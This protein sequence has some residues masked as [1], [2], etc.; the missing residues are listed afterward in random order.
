MWNPKIIEQGELH[1]LRL[2]AERA[3]GADTKQSAYRN[4]C[5]NTSRWLQTRLGGQVGMKDGHFVWLSPDSKYA[6]DLTGDTSGGIMLYKPTDHPFFAGVEPV[7]T[8]LFDDETTHRMIARADDEY[9]NIDSKLSKIALDYA[10]DSHPAQEPQAQ[11]DYDQ[12][13]FHHSP[14]TDEI[15]GEYK[16]VYANGN[17]EISPYSDHE[18]LAQEAGISLDQSGPLAVGYISV[19]RGIAN[20][21]V[22]SNIGAKIIHKIVKDYTDHVGWKWGGLT[23]IT[24]EPIGQGS[25]FAPKKT[26]RW[27]YANGTLYL[28]ERDADLIKQICGSDTNINVSLLSNNVFGACFL[29]QDNIFISSLSKSNDVFFSTKESKSTLSGLVTAFQ[30]VADDKGLTLVSGLPGDGWAD[31]KGGVGDN[32]IK[33]IEDLELDNL[34]D[35]NPKEENDGQFFPS[36]DTR[37]PSGTYKCDHCGR[38]LPTWRSY[39]SHL[40]DHE[41]P[42]DEPNQDGKF[43]ELDNDATFP[44]HFTPLQ[45]E[46]FP[47]ASVKEARRVP[48]FVK[49]ARAKGYDNDDFC[50]YVAFADGDPLAYMSVD[51][52]GNIVGIGGPDSHILKKLFLLNA[53]KR[54]SCLVSG[55]TKGTFSPYGFHMISKNKWKWAAGQDHK[56]MIEDSIPFI[57]D[58][59]DDKITIG[60]PGMKTSQIPGQFTP[61]GIVEGTYEPGGK[62]YIRSATNMPYTIR[63]LV[64][65]F[66]YE[67]PTLEVKSVHL[68][69]EE[70]KDK[71]LA[72]DRANVVEISDDGAS[73]STIPGFGPRQP[74]VYTPDSDTVYL[75]QQRTYHDDIH[76]HLNEDGGSIEDERIEGYYNESGNG[77]YKYYGWG[78]NPHKPRIEDALN[79]HFGIE[80]TSNDWKFSNTQVVEREVT[81]TRP[82]NIKGLEE[83]RPWIYATDKDIVYLGPPGTHHSDLEVFSRDP[84][85]GYLMNDGEVQEYNDF[86]N[87]EKAQKAKDALRDSFNI[88]PHQQNEFKFAAA[89]ISSVVLLDVAKDPAA[90]LA[91]RALQQAGG[92]V[93]AVGGA[94]RDAAM[95]KPSNDVDLMVQGIPAETVEQALK[96]LGD[97]RVDYTGKDFGVFRYK[98]NGHEVEIALPRRE[99]STGDE[100]KDF[101]VE[102]DHTMKPEEDLYRRDFTANAMAVDLA[103]G[104]LL[105][106]YNGAQDIAEGKLRTVHEHALSEDP[107]RVLRGIAAHGKHGLEPDEHTRAQMAN[108]AESLNHLPKERVQAELDKIMSS[109]DPAAA[110]VLAHETGA[111]Q[112][113]LPEVDNAFGYDQN[114]PHHELELGSHLVNVL[115]RTA[116]ITDDP[117]VRLA[118]LL[119]DIG[120]PASEWVDPETG[121]NHFYLGPNGEGANHEEVGAEMTEAR[122]QELKYPNDRV[123]RVRDIVN[124]HMFPAFKTERGARRFINRVGDHADDLMNLRW[125]DQGGKS[126]YPTD[127]TAS[128]D[129]QRALLESVRQGQQPT[130]LSQLAINGND[131][132][133]LGM[134]PGPEIGQTLNRLTEA[135]IEN[136]ELN[137]RES[138]LGLV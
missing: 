104:E 116:E 71:K 95:G 126:E 68:Q 101:D 5:Y 94:V 12:R 65:L 62:V 59:E 11:A 64:Q 72:A 20:W 90:Q 134:Q 45:P 34:Y 74:F 122:L 119:H 33:R 40:L 2:A 88:K 97:G 36:G 85:Y 23:D 117:D 8:D 52:E 111:L 129:D 66:Y 38:L 91:T 19:D 49:D 112:H 73:V 102:A 18:Q 109:A 26:Y 10:G 41:P 67:Q 76:S 1:G 61:G 60:E 132:I 30:E 98:S 133:Q 79:H 87:P 103:T 25:E 16:F 137:N 6:I 121:K 15:D 82:T 83:R 75:G 17:I 138:L 58:V 43:P 57:Y 4:H 47:V 53:K 135:V 127:P 114:N 108:H 89:D 14:T 9:D 92:R 7:D 70:G 50:H 39:R 110:I 13:Y 46:V 120:K 78:N 48:G 27:R 86:G 84:M 55:D 63:H 80:P 107:L 115:K 124:H 118:A 54:F 77:E 125:A 37:E 96:A 99:R 128:V 51:I 22:S 24:G 28:G 131:L 3:W 69:D 35:P 21:S 29:D 113:I 136:P 44:P 31:A 106:P 100:H 56:D 81:Q 105:D 93:F 42:G 32:V 123:K 130:N